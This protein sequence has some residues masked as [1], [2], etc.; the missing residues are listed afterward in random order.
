MNRIY[1]AHHSKNLTC[2]VQVS[3]DT[4][5][6]MGDYLTCI[7]LC[8]KHKG[9]YGKINCRDLETM[10]YECKDCE[11]VRKQWWRGCWKV[12]SQLCKKFYP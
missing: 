7:P 3:Y 5:N 11:K 10:Y 6:L 12:Y 9:S 1:K 4:M 8:D 2:K